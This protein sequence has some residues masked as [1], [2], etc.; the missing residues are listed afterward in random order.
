[1]PEHQWGELIREPDWQGL[2]SQIFNFFNY[3]SS[4]I[5]SQ[6]SHSIVSTIAFVSF[7][8]T[9]QGSFIQHRFWRG[10]YQ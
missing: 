6:S 10:G 8:G 7:I 5:G 1:M 3:L 9:I 4:S 2:L